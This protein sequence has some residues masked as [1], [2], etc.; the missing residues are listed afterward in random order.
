[1][2]A[3][4]VRI[5]ALSAS[6]SYPFLK[7]GTQLTLPAPPFSSILGNI[8]ACAGRPV[9]PHETL[10]GYE[11]ES[12]GQSLDLE[13]TR[14]LQTDK[15]YGRLSDNPERGIAKRQFHVCPR[16]DLYLTETA[17]ERSFYSPATAPCL[18]RSQDLG[19]IR[20]VRRIELTPVETG[21]LGPTVVKF[22][23]MQVG[24]L[25]L[26]PLVDFYRND[27]VGFVREAGRYSRYQFVRTATVN[28]TPELALFH[29]SDSQED[30]AIVL[31]NLAA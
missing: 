7:S 8:S 26:P 12:T 5:E 30:H 17:F 18:G 6:Y 22:P 20:F 24:G 29:P 11:F 16:L 19:W 21:K 2:E 9:G 4:H 13:R 23:N 27:R 14:R 10:I 15:K 31:H 28:R 3:I 1:M 25:V